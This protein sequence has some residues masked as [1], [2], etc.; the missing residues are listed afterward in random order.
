[1]DNSTGRSVDNSKG[2]SHRLNGAAFLQPLSRIP[3]FP[4]DQLGNL[5]YITCSL[6]NGFGAW[7]GW[8]WKSVQGQFWRG[9]TLGL[10]L[11]PYWDYLNR[12]DFTIP[13]W[14]MLD[15]SRPD[16][17]VPSRLASGKGSLWYRVP[18]WLGAKIR[19]VRH[20]VLCG[21]RGHNWWL[22]PSFWP[23]WSN[24]VQ[25]LWRLSTLRSGVLRG[26]YKPSSVLLQSPPVV[27]YSR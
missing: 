1:M 17:A 18:H 5:F 9:D 16:K 15:S 22:G 11:G 6:Q 7:I 20:I 24:T 14:G 25:S 3:T 19:G 12:G 23:S 8:V 26:G 13:D 27:P 4:A 21:Y 10:E 2:K